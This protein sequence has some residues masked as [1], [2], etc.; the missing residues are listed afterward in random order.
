MGLKMLKKLWRGE[1]PLWLNFWVF[2]VLILGSL[3]F[4]LYYLSQPSLNFTAKYGIYP[5][6]I[7]DAFS[8]IYAFIIWLAIW[9]SADKYTGSQLLAHGA[10]LA[11]ILSALY[12]F[13]S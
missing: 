4:L 10:K 5:L 6:S 8:L 1:L 3:R 7:L 9:K 11:V 2:G 12:I 13:E